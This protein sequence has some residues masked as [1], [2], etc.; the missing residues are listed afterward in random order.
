[1][2]RGDFEVIL[3]KLAPDVWIPG[4]RKVRPPNDGGGFLLLMDV[5]VDAIPAPLS[6]ADNGSL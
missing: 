1:M 3:S 6:Q 4:I 2:S 5:E